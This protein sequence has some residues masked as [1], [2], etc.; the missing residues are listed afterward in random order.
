MAKEVTEVLYD[1]KKALDELKKLDKKVDESG[2][3]AKKGF[4]IAG[5]GVDDLADRLS[6][7]NPI[8]G[9]VVSGF[10][11]VAST[12]GLMSISITGAGAAVASLVANFVDLPGLLKDSSVQMNAFNQALDQQLKVRESASSL[13]DAVINAATNRELRGI[14]ERQSDLAIQQ[15]RLSVARTTANEQLAIEQDK[16][17][18]IEAAQAASLR[19]GQDLLQRIADKRL[20]D[21]VSRTEGAGAKTSA[22]AVVDLAARAQTEAQRG[23]LELSDALLDRAKDLSSELGNHKFFTDKIRAAEEANLKATV[24]AANESKRVTDAQKERVAEAK[25]V[26]VEFNKQNQLLTAQ[27]QL[28]S[29][30]SKSTR[31]R[32]T[33]ERRS[34]TADSG[35]RQV[36]TAL[37]SL[38]IELDRGGNSVREDLSTAGKN[39]LATLTGKGRLDLA[40]AGVSSAGV[41]ATKIVAEL[42]KAQREGGVTADTLLSIKDP[43]NNLSAAI[44]ALK[45][46]R[47]EGAIAGGNAVLEER[48]QRVLDAALQA[49]AGATRFIEGDRDVSQVI[50]EGTISAFDRFGDR[51]GPTAESLTALENAANLAAQAVTPTSL[52]NSPTA[53]AAVLPEQTT[54]TATLSGPSPINQTVNVNA[55]VKGGIVDREVTEQIV[56]IV[57]REVRKLTLELN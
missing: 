30:Q 37:R 25:K 20:A 50:S 3:A 46:L 6:R 47:A 24:D 57:R 34:Q 27:S 9:R 2:K 36:D 13:E 40:K 38:R 35:A 43:I 26:T 19:R 16:L 54:A 8:L 1:V 29:G 14:K 44:G 33:T 52:Q 10:S 5:I 32:G 41:E 42:L 51:I 39:L 31:L 28:L 12:S 56:D 15:S 53:A 45:G 55:T 21:E 17:R 48:L 11:S 4:G 22:T 49:R 7:V 18:Q 23:N